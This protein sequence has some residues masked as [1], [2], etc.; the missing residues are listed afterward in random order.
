MSFVSCSTLFGE[1]QQPITLTTED[2]EGNPIKGASCNLTNS[3]GTFFV[4]TPGTVVVKQACGNLKINCTKPGYLKVSEAEL[5]K[6]HKGTTW[7]NIIAGGIVGYVI[8]RA[9]GSAC[10]YPAS[11]VFYLKKIENDETLKVN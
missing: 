10:A 5:E 7:A 3:E 4:T 2:L 6:S 8:D 9:T 11:G 1:D